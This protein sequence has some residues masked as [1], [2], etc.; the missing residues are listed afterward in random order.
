MKPVLEHVQALE[1]GAEPLIVTS[2]ISRSCNVN[3][4]PAGAGPGETVGVA[5]I[6]AIP[7]GS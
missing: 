5:K 1:K 4:I 2:E 3:Q 7:S 6:T